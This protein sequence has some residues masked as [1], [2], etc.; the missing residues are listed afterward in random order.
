MFSMWTFTECP[1]Q[2][3]NRAATG[4]F[5][6]P[7]SP[8]L[9]NAIPEWSLWPRNR[10]VQMHLFCVVWLRRHVGINCGSSVM[11]GAITADRPAGDT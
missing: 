10:A 3:W 9:Q 7:F 4:L 8:S 6:S 2:A 5:L 11:A 1:A